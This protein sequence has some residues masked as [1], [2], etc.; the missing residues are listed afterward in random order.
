MFLKST[1]RRSEMS[2]VAYFASLQG[3]DIPQ[4][5]VAWQ[6]KRLSSFTIF[7]HHFESLYVVLLTLYILNS[8]FQVVSMCVA[9]R[10]LFLEGSDNGYS[11]FDQIECS[12]TLHD[13]RK[14]RKS[15]CPKRPFDDV[16]LQ[17]VFWV[18][19]VILVTECVAA[20]IPTRTR[21]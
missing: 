21:S 5:W 6:S 13:A 9:L 19:Y 16:P 3:K 14:A 12:N 10:V 7:H 8:V 2:C 17:G 11:W 18:R 4:A 15:A 20:K 1:F